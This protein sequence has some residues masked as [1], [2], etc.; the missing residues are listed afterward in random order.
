[1]QTLLTPS[2]DSPPAWE[3]K[4]TIA[5]T[6]QAKT[7]T[8]IHPQKIK[9][10]FLFI[11]RHPDGC[12]YPQL[13]EKL[14]QRTKL[15][16]SVVTTFQTLSAEHSGVMKRGFEVLC[17][18]TGCVPNV[19]CPSQERGMTNRGKGPAVLCAGVCH[20]VLLHSSETVLEAKAEQSNHRL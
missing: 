16:K 6:L 19:G 15:C 14:G 1:M 9:L 18:S 5:R 7:S 20:A 2:S 11:H 4:T 17:L 10:N 8:A 3:P 12:L 13:M